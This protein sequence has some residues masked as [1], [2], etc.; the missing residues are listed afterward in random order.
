MMDSSKNP[1]VGRRRTKP[2][3]PPHSPLLIEE[4]N[5]GVYVARCLQCGLMGP[6]RENAEE[7]KLAFPEESV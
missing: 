5:E 2:S 6:A 1:N 3:C 4:V 7:A